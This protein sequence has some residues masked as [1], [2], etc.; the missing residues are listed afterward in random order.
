VR[1]RLR[2][3]AALA[4]FSARTAV[5]QARVLSAPAEPSLLGI[6][7]EWSRASSLGDLRE[8]KLRMR[9]VELRVW[10]GYGMGATQGVVLRR[11]G[12][13]WSAFLA[14]V[15]RCAIQIPIA[16][17]DTASAGT[18][19][20]FVVEARRRCDTPLTNVGA[21]MRIITA[22]TLAVDSLSVPDSVVANAWTAAVGAGVLQL[23]PQVQRSAVP[24]SDFTYVVEVRRGNEY[25]A[26]QIEHVEQPESDADR[27]IQAVY[28]AVG[29]LLPPRLLLKP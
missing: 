16:V 6:T 24:S 9:D 14:Q 18:M 13:R 10:G 26:S 15:R 5:A 17:G 8:L 19:H 11:S 28:A 23:P 3:A 27:Q 2:L 29:R 22:D 20:G 21:G 4:A 25:R 1:A 7:R 12:D